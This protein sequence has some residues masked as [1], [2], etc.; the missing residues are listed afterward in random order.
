MMMTTCQ[1]RSHVPQLLPTPQWPLQTA[2]ILLLCWVV[3]LGME[4]LRTW[5]STALFVPSMS[6]ASSS[7]RV[8]CFRFVSSRPGS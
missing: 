2:P 3:Q 4:T 1:Y 7:L 5:T 8:V 6:L